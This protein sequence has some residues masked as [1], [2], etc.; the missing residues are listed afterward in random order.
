MIEGNDKLKRPI[1]KDDKI[2]RFELFNDSNTASSITL[3]PFRIVYPINE[4]FEDLISTNIILKKPIFSNNNSSKKLTNFKKQKTKIPKKR[5]KRKNIFLVNS[6]NKI[7][8]DVDL[9][10]TTFSSNNSL[11]E[12]NIFQGITNSPEK[13]FI[14]KKRGRLPKILNFRNDEDYNNRHSRYKRDNI[15]RKIQIHYLTFLVKFANYK[16][17]KSLSKDHPLF[18]DLA[19]YIKKNIKRNFVNKIKH[20]KIG[21]VLKNE[22]STKS[23]L[24]KF[25][26]E[27]IFD[28]VYNT[29]K[30]MKK[31]LNINYL[32]FFREV[33]AADLFESSTYLTRYY[34][35]PLKI[36][37]LEDFFKDELYKFG[38]ENNEKDIKYVE[39]IKEICKKEYKLEENNGGSIKEKKKEKVISK[40][41]EKKEEE[42]K[43]IF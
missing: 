20:S 32:V 7:S 33:Y 25:S 1:F 37:I 3:P 38:E 2:N 26:N 42:R 31:L 22:A 18:T 39:H 10:P 14:Q 36:E 16:I 41:D 35:V 6:P 29:S 12:Q 34:R 43:I 13:I 17:K 11:N 8:N 40:T 30:E 4:K 15:L 5:K 27:E 19:H 9:S 21:E 23:K 24:V 28:S